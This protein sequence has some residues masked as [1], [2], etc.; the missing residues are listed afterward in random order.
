[1]HGGRDYDA[2]WG[3]RM[4]GEGVYAGMIAARFRKAARRLGLDRDVPPLRSD[5]FAVPAKAGDQLSLF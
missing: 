5:L 4:R 2:R 3:H 1:M